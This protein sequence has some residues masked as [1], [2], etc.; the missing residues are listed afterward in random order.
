[1]TAAICDEIKLQRNYLESEVVNTVYFGG[2]TPSL[3]SQGQ[4]DQILNTLAKYHNINE[5]A[6]ISFEA[7]PDDLDIKKLGE[8]SESG[9]N[10]LSIGIQSFSEE[11]LKYLNRAHNR[12]QALD[13]IHWAREAGFD[14]IS[15]DLIYG[16]PIN[17]HIGWKRDLKTILEIKPEHISSYC[18]TIEPQTVF[19]HRAKKGQFPKQ[20]EEFEAEQ[21]DMLISQLTSAGYL[22]YE[23]SNF[24]LPE[25]YSKHNSN[26]WKQKKYLGLGPGAHSYNMKERQYNVSHNHKYMSSIQGGTV[27]A[28]YEVLTL[29]EKINEYIL[30]TIRTIW[31]CDLSYLK[32]RHGYDLYSRKYS[33]LNDLISNKFA[34]LEG[35]SLKLTEE[36]LLLA[37]EISSAL[38][39]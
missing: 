19:G 36:G 32:D 6:E 20:D 1:M 2:G 14:N 22:H 21:Y 16:I 35:T 28:D 37:D 30:T 11:V 27:P 38:F 33:Y 23:V 8:L 18:L 29:E 31:G 17:N 26:Y 12:G 5:N 25:K 34:M 9:I 7:N 24:C 39:V 3:L 10:R 4:V 15:I 13:S